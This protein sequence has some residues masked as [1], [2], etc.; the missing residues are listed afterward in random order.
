M[1]MKRKLLA[2]LISCVLAATAFLV[3]LKIHRTNPTLTLQL[4]QKQPL[5]KNQNQ[6]NLPQHL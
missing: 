6:M 5:R 1:K 3:V 4:K 2:L